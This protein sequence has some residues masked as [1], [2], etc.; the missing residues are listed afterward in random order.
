MG[1]RETAGRLTGGW[2]L[3]VFAMELRRIVT[4]RADFWVNFIG[5]TFFAIVIAYFLWSSIFDTLGTDKLNG[6]T[7]RKMIIYYLLVPLVFRIQQ[8]QTI[9]S[10]SRE[11]YEGSLNKFLLYPINFYGYKVITHLAS[12]SFYYIQIGLIIVIYQAFFYDPEVFYLTPLKALYFTLAMLVI[13]IAY[14]CLNSLSELVAFWADYIW[15]LGVIL[16]FMVSFL[17]GALIPLTFFPAWAQ[18]ALAYTPFPYMISFPMNILLEGVEFQTFAFN[19]A[20]LVCWTLVFYAASRALWNRGRY[21][22][23]GVGI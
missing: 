11:I 12:A 17:G 5:Q 4:Y 21:S 6:F 15:S 22:Y 20:V 1:W 16:R 18:E 3:N 14:F 23:T 2:K 8:G 10:I 7:M 19:M 9:G 13:S